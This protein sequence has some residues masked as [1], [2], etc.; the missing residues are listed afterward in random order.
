MS[1]V[2]TKDKIV[3]NPN[4]FEPLVDYKLNDEEKKV[5]LNQ[6]FWKKILA[7]GE[8]KISWKAISRFFC[9]LCTSNKQVTI[10]VIKVGIEELNNADDNL[11]VYLKMFEA[12]ILLDD[13][14]KPSRGKLIWERLMTIFKEGIKYYHFSITLLDFFF[15]SCGRHAIIL[16]LFSDYLSDNKNLYRNIEEWIKSLKDLSYH[17]NSG[18]FSIYKKKK[19]AFN[20]QILQISKII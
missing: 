8:S 9:H 12:L 13:E 2:A 4:L 1:H 3:I 14:F 5:L 10:D 15:K 20:T 19:A 17:L 18:N 6:G 16:K 11:K 7:E